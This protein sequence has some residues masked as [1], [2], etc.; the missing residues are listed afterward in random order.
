MYLSEKTFVMKFLAGLACLGVTTIPF[1]NQQFY[2]GADSMRQLFSQITDKMGSRVNELS[3][4]FLRNPMG[5]IYTEF[6]EGIARQ[7]GG[8]LSFE[9]PQYVSATIKLDESGARY[10]LDSKNLDI[11]TETI[12]DFSR[13]FCKGAGITIKR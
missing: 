10:I 4:L 6:K 9:N 11:E 3:M 12:L 13:E 2:S 1:D 7:N 5:G 8:L